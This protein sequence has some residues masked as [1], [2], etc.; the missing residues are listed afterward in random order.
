MSVYQKICQLAKATGTKATATDPMGLCFGFEMTDSSGSCRLVMSLPDRD[1]QSTE[2]YFSLGIFAEGKY[3][4][5]D[6]LVNGLCASTRAR[7]HDRFQEFALLVGALEQA[8]DYYTGL[9]AECEVLPD[10]TEKYTVTRIYS[11][12]D[13]KEPTV[14]VV[15][16]FYDDGYITR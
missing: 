6:R 14:T 5:E 9:K 10:G 12:A 11:P 1:G 13:A 2:V 15:A 8:L 7:F 4:V 16:E 3:S